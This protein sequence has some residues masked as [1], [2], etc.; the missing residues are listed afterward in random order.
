MSELAGVD[1]RLWM[2]RGRTQFGVGVG[3]LGAVAPSSDPHGAAALAL[4]GASPALTLGVRHHL[5]AEST[6]Y[7]DAYG[8]R[9]LAGEPHA[10][11]VN[12]KVGVEWKPAK[13]RFGFEHGALGI[14]LDSG[15]RLALKAHHGGLGLYLRGQF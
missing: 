8:T 3:S 10:G 12:A 1:Y 9:T 6:V 15:Y 7:A 4:V 11:Y 13:P 2:G 14:H 5:T